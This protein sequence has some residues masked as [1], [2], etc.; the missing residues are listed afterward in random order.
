MIGQTAEGLCAD[1]ILDTRLCQCSHFRR[2]E[3]A[4]A[5]DYALIDVLVSKL[6]QVLEVVERLEASL[7]LHDLDKLLLLGIDEII[8]YLVENGLLGGVVVYLS[9]VK[10]A[11]RAVH[12]ELQQ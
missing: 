9:V 12:N 6:S 5:H 8:A 7:L 2:Y 11:C 1:D 10:G 4:L 3:P